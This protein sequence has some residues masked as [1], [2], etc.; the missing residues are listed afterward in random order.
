M[1]AQDVELSTEEMS[2]EKEF[3]IILSSTSYK[4]ALRTAKE[5]ATKL[6]YKLDLRDLQMNKE[7]GLTWD[8]KTCENEWDEF[9]CYVA[10]GRYDDGS[11]VSIEYSDAYQGFRKG[12]Y[13]VI[14]AAGEKGSTEV[15][16]ALTKAKSF[17]KTAYSKSTK[18]YMGC[19]H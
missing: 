15:K 12:Y 13:I 3:V 1:I 7:S 10:R 11:Y 6:Q 9:P 8:K 4:A 14:V 16:T 2:V 5:A 17:Y 19:M 18:V